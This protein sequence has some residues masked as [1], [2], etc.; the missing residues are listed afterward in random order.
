M[1]QAGGGGTLR[2]AVRSTW[3]AASVCLFSS[4]WS[5]CSVF[6]CNLSRSGTA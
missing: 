2:A 6:S 5:K 1:K 3:K 4:R